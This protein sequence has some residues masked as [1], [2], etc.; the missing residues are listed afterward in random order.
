MVTIVIAQIPIND[1]TKKRAKMHNQTIRIFL[2]NIDTPI[3]NIILLG[4]TK[5]QYISPVFQIYQ[6][7]ESIQKLCFAI[8]IDYNLIDEFPV[9]LTLVF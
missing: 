4:I 1:K 7:A 6:I 9:L 5:A 2:N 8:S 3:N